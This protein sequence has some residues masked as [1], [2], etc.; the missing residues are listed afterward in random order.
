MRLTMKLCQAQVYLMLGVQEFNFEQKEYV[1]YNVLQNMV[2]QFDNPTH[3]QYLIGL[4]AWLRFYSRLVAHLPE[5]D[6][7]DKVQVEFDKL[8]VGYEDLL[9]VQPSKQ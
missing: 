9:E 7:R 4:A 6:V 2:K 1:M 8:V 3:K 5:G